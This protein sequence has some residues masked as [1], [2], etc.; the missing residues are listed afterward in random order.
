MGKPPVKDP[1]TKKLPEEQIELCNRQSNFDIRGVVAK[2]VTPEK[3]YK[4]KNIH[5]TLKNNTCHLDAIWSI[6]ADKEGIHPGAGGFDHPTWWKFW[7]KLTDA[8]KLAYELDSPW[9]IPTEGEMMALGLD[10]EVSYIGQGRSTK[11]LIDIS[12]N[13]VGCHI[14]AYKICPYDKKDRAF[15]YK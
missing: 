14:E 7:N 6:F 1:V 8:R 10:K 5:H 11:Y 2:T 3:M 12:Q 4:V 9:Y 13:E 15:D